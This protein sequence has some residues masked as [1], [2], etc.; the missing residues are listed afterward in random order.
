MRSED[1]AMKANAITTTWDASPQP[2][3]QSPPSDVTGSRFFES[4]AL[5]HF[6]ALLRYAASL[7]GNEDDAQELTQETFFEAWRCFDRYEPGTNCKAWLFRIFRNLLSNR[8][9]RERLAGQVVEL[10][11]QESPDTLLSDRATQPTSF[12]EIESGEIIAALR[13]LPRDHQD[14]LVLLMEGYAYREIAELLHIPIGTVMSRI[15]R[16][17]EALRN[18]L[19]KGLVN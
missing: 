17:R 16:A 10:D 11:A 6:R 3:G 4:E 8:R 18:R 5:V 13:S 14:V 12:D 19:P 7:L 1:I 2:W 9:R 15:H